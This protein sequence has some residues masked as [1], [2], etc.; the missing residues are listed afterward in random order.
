MSVCSLLYSFISI[1]NLFSA[2][3]TSTS[4]QTF[5]SP[6]SSTITL[7]SKLIS[8]RFIA[9]LNFTA[10]PSLLVSMAFSYTTALF[11]RFFITKMSL[12]SR[13]MFETA[14]FKV[15]LSYYTSRISF[16]SYFFPPIIKLCSFDELTKWMGTTFDKDYQLNSRGRVQMS[17]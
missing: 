12:F 17:F 8:L 15:I 6:Q 7:N 4:F 10:F 5:Y 2:K 13:L 1:V 16:V 14:S 11:F 9:Y 3:G